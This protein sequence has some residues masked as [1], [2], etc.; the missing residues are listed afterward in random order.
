ME[1][2]NL[3]LRR[4]KAR[5]TMLYKINWGLVEVPKDNLT[6]SDRRTRGKHKFRQISTNK[7]FYKFSFYPRTISDWNSLPEAIGM[8]DTL[9][10][11]K[12]GISTLTLEGSTTTY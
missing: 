4:K 10:S 5:L 11:F 9:E 1:W 12:S 8:S 3:E 2:E 6:I 7:D